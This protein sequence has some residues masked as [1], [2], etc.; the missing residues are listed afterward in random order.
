MPA[1]RTLALAGAAAVALSLALPL[2]ATAAATPSATPSAMTLVA[3]MADR[4]GVRMTQRQDEGP[5]AVVADGLCTFL[6]KGG[7]VRGLI[8]KD[9]T[10]LLFNTRANAA[11]YAGC[12]DDT[13]RALGRTVISFGNP[14]RMG[15]ARRHN[16]VVTARD[17]R[18]THPARKNKLNRIRQALTEAGLPMRDAHFDTGFER[19]GWATVIPGA[20]DMAATKQTDVIVFETRAKAEDYV[21]NADDHTYR[22]GRVVL[23]FGNPALLGKDRRATYAAALRHVLASGSTSTAGATVSQVAR[24]SRVGPRFTAGCGG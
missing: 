13:A 15:S 19:A 11:A 8:T 22:R 21:G 6:E 17:Y 14:A 9:A 7:C 3:K 24:A 10:L 12:G 1:S 4:P 20:V 23:S 18:E 2:P 5:D 16:Y